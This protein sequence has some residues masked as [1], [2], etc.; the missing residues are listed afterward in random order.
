[1]NHLL[2]FEDF[3]VLTL[4]KNVPKDV[5]L[6]NTCKTWAKSKYDVWPSAYAVGA[7]QRY[8][9]KVVNGRRKKDKK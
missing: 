3:G 8:K 9:V 7:P 6:W 4:E 5:A 2:I 1:M